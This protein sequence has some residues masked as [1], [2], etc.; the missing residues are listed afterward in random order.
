MR[1]TLLVLP[2][3]VLLI[4]A[5]GASIPASAAAPATPASF[6]SVTAAP[7]PGV[8]EVTFTWVQSGSNT[9]GYVL[10]TALSTWSDT[11]PNMA[12]TGRAQ[13]STAISKSLRSLT[14]T[15]AQVAADSAPVA[16]GNHLYFRFAAVNTNSSGTTTKN[17]PYLRAVLPEPVPAST[18]AGRIRV[19]SFNVRTARATTDSRTWLQRAPDVAGQIV[20]YNPGLVGLQELGPGRADGKTGTLGGTA[21]QTKSLLT[22]L[23]QVGGSKYDLVQTTPYVAPSV[24]AGT[25]GMRMLYDHTRYTLVSNCPEDTDGHAYSSL[26]SVKLPILSSDP[27]NARR[28]AVFAEFVDQATGAHFWFASVHLDERHSDTRATEVSYDGLRKSQASTMS[29]AINAAN[30]ANLPVIITGDMNSW[31]NNFVNNSPHDLLVSQGYYDTSAA[32][33]RVN[34]QYSTVNHFDTTVKAGAQGVGSRID[35]IFVKGA[36]GASEF[37]NIVQV[38]D[39]A[40]P[41]DHNL[42]LADFAPFGQRAPVSPW[43]PTQV[44]S[45]RSHPSPAPSPSPSPS[46]SPPFSARPTS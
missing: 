21:S 46:A 2:A 14:L 34:F 39:S 43:A 31:Q 29:A 4:A 19:G 37:Q 5:S 36:S 44:R 45:R 6:T 41:S 24:V 7:G 30:V 18:T 28:R 3:A 32:V 42:I 27:E 15:A 12:K 38:T 23:D 11:D 26:C 17:Y 25:Q 13:K 9:T 33:K 22:A 35:M 1:R 10:R 40:R 20:Q 8:G 16:S